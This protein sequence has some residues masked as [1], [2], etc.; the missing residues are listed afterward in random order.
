MHWKHWD[1]GLR[2]SR[3]DGVKI[4]IMYGRTSQIMSRQGAEEEEHRVRG[5][6]KP[7]HEGPGAFM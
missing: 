3:R 4:L 2:D 7:R 5:R 1:A 6:E